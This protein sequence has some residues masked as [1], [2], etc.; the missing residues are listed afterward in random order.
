MGWQ[1][2]IQFAGYFLYLSKIASLNLGWLCIHRDFKFCKCYN[3]SLIEL[4]RGIG[5]EFKRVMEVF[6]A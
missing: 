2:T 6:K 1:S 3:V 5:T 4:Q